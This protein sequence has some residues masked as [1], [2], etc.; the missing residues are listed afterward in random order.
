MSGMG[1]AL[2]VGGRPNRSPVSWLVLT[3]GA[4]VVFLGGVVAMPPSAGAAPATIGVGSFPRGVAFSPDGSFA[5]VTNSGS[6]SVSR[7]RTADGTVTATVAVGDTPWD[8]AISPDGLFAYVTSIGTGSV[9]RIRTSDDTV[10]ASVPLGGGPLGVA[11]AP[12]GSFA[13]VGEVGTNRVSR[14][15][16]SDNTVVA[17]AAIGGQGTDVA[18]SPDGTFAYAVSDTTDTL[19]RI[20]TSDMTITDTVQVGSM[21]RNL[22]ISPGGTFAY[23]ANHHAGTISRVRTSDTT[24]T[25]TFPVAIS[26]LGLAFTPDGSTAFATDFPANSVA[27]IRTSDDTVTAAIPVGTGPFDVAVSPTEAMAYVVNSSSGSVSVLRP[28]TAPTL[29]LAT[30]GD[31]RCAVSFTSPSSDGGLAVSTYEYSTDDGASWLPRN[32]ASPDS[33]MDIPGLSNGQTYQVRARA[34]NPVGPG[35][36][37]NAVACT[38]TPGTS[39]VPLTGPV[40]AAD[41][42]ALEGAEVAFP[43]QKVKLTPQVPLAVPVAGQFGVPTDAGAVSLNVTVVDPEDSGFLTVY[44][45][46]APVPDASNLNYVRGQIVPN[47]VL[48]GVGPGGTVC[49]YSQVVTDV[50][51]DV[52][53]YLPIGGG[54]NPL[55]PVRAADTRVGEGAGVPFPVVKGPLAPQTPLEVPV[56]GLFAVPADAGAVSLNVTVAQPDAP[57]FVTVYPCG[58][59]WPFASNLNFVTGQT[60]P[61][62]VVTGLGGEGKVCVYSQV[63]TDVVVDLNGW[64]TGP[65]GFT[66]MTP[67]RVADTRAGFGAGVAFPPQK[68]QLAARTPLEV[69]VAGSFGVPVDAAAVSLNVTAA[70][71]TGPGFLTVYPCGQPWPL[72]SNLNYS[73]GQTVPNAVLTGLGT[74]GKV[75][76]Y[77]MTP[78]DVF[79]DLNG[80]FPHPLS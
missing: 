67:V 18:I 35:A 34:V 76:I 73:R 23:V 16:T 24:V 56:A 4:L 17:T 6:D 7:I 14:I 28:P 61:N 57:G 5:Y 32:P 21:P 79:V 41:T 19:S 36:V 78:T 74:G 68:L 45:C 15:R 44:P 51:V 3:V 65:P 27:R 63:A 66:P 43:V 26:V 30:P 50:V 47:A 31:G 52:T 13:L 55:T 54:F 12:D 39:F 33:P 20:R 62:A 9:W 38:P 64:F 11:I 70:N 42:R 29:A 60:T 40:R 72:A 69:P 48:S 46:G 2:E 22:A 10:T 80:W 58:Q 37:S 59:P 25:N 1:T 53:G 75:C 49:V 8:V 71:P 77:S